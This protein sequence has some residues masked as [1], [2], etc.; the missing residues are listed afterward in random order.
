MFSCCRKEGSKDLSR[1]KKALLIGILYKGTRSELH[2]CINDTKNLKKFL[3]THG[4]KEEDI[5][6]LNDETGVESLP[7]KLTILK[8]IDKIISEADENT[9]L[10]IQY[11]GHGTHT[12]DRTGDE[13]DNE[14]ECLCALDGII[15]DD[16]LR[17]LVNKL[18]K[19]ARLLFLSDSCHS[20]SILDLQTCYTIDLSDDDRS[21]FTAR[22][23]TRIDATDSFV[24]CISGCEDSATSADYHGRSPYSMFKEFQGAMTNALLTTLLDLESQ[25]KEIT[26]KRLMK[27]VT[28]RIINSGFTQRPQF[29]SGYV[30]DLNERV[31]L[32][33]NDIL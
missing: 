2:G 15:I 26:Y 20:G 23:N 9:D 19:G 21:K 22:K 24:V 14:D 29:S 1:T 30:L 6:M 17:K 11:S 7:T 12:R 18:K 8:A 3:L 32:F 31:S 27:G 13:E 28:S 10:V 33:T 5:V 16:E 25:N 4:Y